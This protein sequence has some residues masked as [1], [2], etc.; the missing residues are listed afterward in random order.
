MW[1]LEW[2]LRKAQTIL[3][4]F[5][6][7]L[8]TI[9]RSEIIKQE[10]QLRSSHILSWYRGMIHERFDMINAF[11]KNAHNVKIMNIKILII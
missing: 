1:S 7:M 6:I 4:D 5:L 8:V 11:M 2:W 3:L 10:A 9:L